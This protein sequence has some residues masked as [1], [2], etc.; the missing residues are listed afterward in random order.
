ML[1]DD[2]LAAQ[3]FERLRS[4]LPQTLVDGDG[5]CWH[6]VGLNEPGAVAS[7]GSASGG[8]R[9]NG[10]GRWRDRDLGAAEQ[11]A[12]ARRDVNGHD[13]DVRALAVLPDGSLASGGEDDSIRLWKHARRLP[14][15]DFVTSLRVLADGTLASASYDGTIRLWA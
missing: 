9:G 11:P 10:C 8:R 7:G 6:L 3:L 12:R 1:D 14:H 4:C 13:S 5:V 15:G 2:R